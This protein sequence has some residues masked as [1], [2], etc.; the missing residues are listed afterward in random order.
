[1]LD[2][3]A[4]EEMTGEAGDTQILTFILGCDWRV[5]PVI[6]EHCHQPS[7][8]PLHESS[9]AFL[10][11]ILIWTWPPFGKKSKSLDCLWPVAS[12]LSE[13]TNRLSKHQRIKT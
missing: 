4:M 1:M 9:K 13:Y 6:S 2:K 11:L 10:V 8:F 3:G 5:N 12:W 7:D